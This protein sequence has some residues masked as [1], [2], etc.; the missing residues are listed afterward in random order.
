MKNFQGSIS[1]NYNYKT[2]NLIKLILAGVFALLFSGLVAQENPLWLRY[3]SI[4]PDGQTIA[5]CYKGDIFLVS[6]KGGKATQLTTHP[7]YDS[8]PVWSPDGK[9]IAFTS[10]R[11]NAMDLF[12]IPVGG[13]TPRQLTTFSGSATPECFTP[14]GKSILFRSSLMPDQNYGQYPS[15]SQIYKISTEGGRPELFLTFDAYNIHF[16]KAGNKI[17]YHDKKGYEDEWRKHH[18]SSVCR[19]I[20]EHDLSNGT[21]TNLT[22]KQVE[23]RYPVLSADESTIYFLSERF[24]DFNVCRM[25]LGNRADI[26]QLTRFSKHPVR[27]LSRSKDDL[28]CFTYDGEIYTL[29]PGKQPK[30]VDIQVVMDN[31]EPAV[32]KY[33]WNG[34]AS[35]IAIAPN[36]QEFA[37]V[38]RGDVFVANSEYGTTQRITNTAARE[39][40][41]HFSPDGRSLVYASERDGQW[42]LYISR[43]KNKEDKS[44]AYAR[45]IEEEPLTKGSNACFQPAFS[46]DGKEVAYLENRTEIKVINLKNKKTRTVLPAKYNYSY[47]DGDQSFEWSPDGRW[48]LAKFFEEGG[49]QHPDIALIKADG[50]GEIHNLTNSGYSDANPRWM[51]NGKAIIWQSD[52]QGMR[53]HGSWGAQSD[54]YALFLDPEAY[55]YFN[56]SKEER[57]L[58][59]EFKEL[60]KKKEAEEKAKADKKEKKKAEKKEQKEE[61]AKKGKKDQK[62]PKSEGAKKEGE[63]KKEE[64]NKLP[65]LKIDLQ[66]LENRMV[67]MTINSSNLGD[68]V[69]TNDGNKLYYLAA[70]EGGYD[71]WVRDFENKSTRILS[72]MGRGGSLELSKDGRNLYLLSGGQIFTINQGNGQLKQLNYKANFELKRA[73]ERASLFNHVWQQVYDKFYDKDFKGVDWPYYKKAYAR[74]LPYINNNFDFA[75]V[76][77]EMLGELNASHTGARYGE[78]INR[79]GTALLGAF[80][81]LSY[82][83]DGLRIS[84]ILEEGPLDLFNKKIKPGMIIRAINYQPIKKGE[85]YYPLFEGLAGKR[86][87]LTIYDPVKKQEFEEYVKPIGN[88]SG[89]L[90]ERW[91]KQR[92]HIVDSLSK[93]Q[94]GYIH[95]ASMNSSSFRKTYSELLGRYRNRKAIIIDTRNNGGGWLHE[96]LIHLLSGKQF[97]TFVPRGQFIGI[98][99]FAQWTKPS[100]VLISENNYS[101]A[102]GFPWAYKELK[103]GKLIGM[104]VPGTMTAVWWENMMNGITFGIPQVGMK[105]NQGRILENM[106]LE[107][108]IKVNNDP[109]SAIQGRDLQLEAAVKSLME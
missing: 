81:D 2:M 49:W 33:S 40:N 21:F 26:K 51:M 22:D 99:P 101:N 38:I 10:Q 69:L 107:P 103:I 25:A 29:E 36:G 85:D 104:P 31:T 68:A 37:F 83:G 74:F 94:I 9:T 16:N 91:V 97:A 12:T 86:T 18:T 20:W 61:K 7:G 60:Q 93:G 95:V 65:E 50:K 78:G 15:N 32:S 88:Q 67:R 14:D 105:D 82:K 108:D 5:F 59:K 30:K 66:N 75:D 57:A 55:E 90:Y 87:L 44:F 109:A 43:I 28:L 76:L 54:I 6:S 8:R 102:H 4:S 70:F 63:G 35:E 24:G 52:R 80:Y 106:Q 98:D 64:E 58:D 79:P 73:E 62:D 77:G 27:F 47:T 92:Q 45:E 72:K 19:D 42:N 17:Y 39:K 56:M 41:I 46:P 3:P 34:G 13:G 53:S 84:E 11:N 100:A 23:D 89:L 71:L 1:H 48:I 96:D